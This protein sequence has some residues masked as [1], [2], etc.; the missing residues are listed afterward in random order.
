MRNI[1]RKINRKKYS[2]G[3]LVRVINSCSKDPKEAT[4]ALV[5]LLASGRVQLQSHGTLK[6]VE[7]AS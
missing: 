5:D 7:V 3:D 6:R 1:Y 2:L 4:A